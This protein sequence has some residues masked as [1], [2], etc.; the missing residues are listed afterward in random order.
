MK[1][2]GFLQKSPVCKIDAF[3]IYF[4][5]PLK[6]DRLSKEANSGSLML[7]Q[8]TRQNCLD[9]SAN[10][11]DSQRSGMVGQKSRA[12]S[13]DN[14]VNCLDIQTDNLDSQ[15]GSLC[16]QTGYP[17]IHTDTLAS[18]SDYIGSLRLTKQFDTL[19]TLLERLFRQ[20]NMLQ[21]VR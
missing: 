20:A 1:R 8:T 12:D 10:S 19:P 2:L 14:L 16:Y 11:L 6:H 18:Q 4:F 13:L 17:S 15:I 21:T 3:T 5:I 9:T 7:V